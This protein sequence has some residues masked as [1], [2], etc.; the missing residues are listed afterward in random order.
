MRPPKNGQL[1]PSPLS[2]AEPVDSAQVDSALIALQPLLNRN[3]H[4]LGRQILASNRSDTAA[5]SFATAHFKGY[6]FKKGTRAICAR[7]PDIGC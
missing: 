6:L 7:K 1:T 4:K 5:T 2:V 3:I